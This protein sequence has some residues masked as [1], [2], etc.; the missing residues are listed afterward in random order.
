MLWTLEEVDN[1][2]KRQ[3]NPR[4]HPYTCP[5]CSSTLKPTPEGWVCYEHGLVQTWARKED[6]NGANNE[7]RSTLFG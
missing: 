5:Q 3:S 1:L 4:M 6:L 7:K 2:A